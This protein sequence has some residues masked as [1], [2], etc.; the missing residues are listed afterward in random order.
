MTATPSGAARFAWVSRN[1]EWKIQTQTDSLVQ[2]FGPSDRNSTASAFVV[3]KIPIG[4]ERYEITM[5]SACTN[6]FG[7]V[8]EPLILKAHF[9]SY[10]FG[11][12][13]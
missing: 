9:T 5:R 4:G 11:E 12:V 13:H 8:P 3:N 6:M 2:T 7:C 1:S 10:V